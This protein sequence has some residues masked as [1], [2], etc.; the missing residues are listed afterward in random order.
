MKKFFYFFIFV[1][2]FPCFCDTITG[3]IQTKEKKAISSAN[4]SIFN[5][6]QTGK[7][8]LKTVISD[9][10]GKFKIDNLETGYY[11]I[12]VQK[13]G[14]CDSTLGK[15][16][17]N[18][19]KF[20]VVK[21]EII[22]SIPGAISGFVY[23]QEGKPISGAK[24]FI[25][26]DIYT[27]T[28]SK[29]FYKL[30]GLNPGTKYIYVQADGFVKEH[31]NTVVEEG[32]E[33]GGINFSLPYAGS[34]K[35]IIVDSETEKPIDNVDI[36][37]SGTSFGSTKTNKNGYFYIDGLKPG[38]YSLYAYRQGYEDIRIEKKF[39]LKPK[40]TVDA[41]KIQMKIRAKYFHL[42]SKEWLFTP[43][44]KVK[45]YFNAFRI[46]SATID[47]Y[48]IDLLNEINKTKLRDISINEILMSS[49]LS[50]KSPVLSKKFEITYPTPLTE[51]Y[52]RSFLLD[53][54]PE[55]AYVFALKPEGFAEIKGWFF[56][57]DIGFISKISNK[58]TNI[59]LFSLTKGDILPDIQ[60]F[61]FD[62]LWN[63][64]AT[65][66]TDSNG[67][68]NFESFNKFIA[69]KGNSFAFS[70]TCNSIYGGTYENKTVYAYT[71]RPVYRP[72]QVVNFKAIPRIDMGDKYSV[73]EF[74]SCEIKVKLPDETVV[75]ETQIIPGTTNSIYGSYTLPEEPPL[76]TYKIEFMTIGKNELSGYCNFKVL[77]YRKPEFSIDI[78]TDKN[79]YLPGEKIKVLIT[80][81]YYFG[82]PVKNTDVLWAIYSRQIWENDNDDYEYGEEYGGW[83]KGGLVCSGKGTTDENGIYLIEIPTQLSYEIKQIFTIE[84]RMTDESRREIIQSTKI[85]IVPGS[86]EIAITTS[87]YIY[88][89]EEEIPVYLSIK[90]YD[91]REFKGKKQ[92]KLIVS[93]EKYDKNKRRWSYN[94]IISKNV[95]LN[96]A[97]TTFNIK[98]GI[99]G[100]IRII[101]QGIDEY[102]NI[103]SATKYV[104]IT[105][106]DY[107]SQW[108]GKKELEIVSD[109]KKY[110][111]GE[112]AKI[113]INSSYSDLTILYTIEGYEIFENRVIK[114]NG[115]SVLLELPIKYE[116]I[117]NIYITIC[118]V[119]NKSFLY[120]SKSLV[121]S[122]DD[123]FLNVEIT[124]DKPKYQP[125]EKAKYLIKIKDNTGN[126]VSAEFSMGVVDEA[127]Y[128]ISNE[129]V[130]EIGDFFY[131]LKGNNVITEYSF[132]RWYYGGAGKDFAQQDI[133][134]NFKD[135]AFWLPLALTD[136]N[137]IAKIEVELPDN[138]TTWRA[139]IRSVTNDTKVG[140]G[141]NN[142]T[143]AKPL[144]ANLITPRFFVE[145]DRLL[146]SGVIHNYTG[147]QQKIYT[148]IHAE[149]LDILEETEK[150]IELPSG[151]SARVDWKVKVNSVKHAIITLYAKSSEFSDGM[152][153]KIP[154]FLYGTDERYVFAGQC[155]DVRVDTFYL[156]IGTIPSSI[157]I[158]SYIY[159]S[160]VSGM[161]TSLEALS[162]YP[163]GC[164]EQTLNGFLPAIQV[165]DTL[166]KIKS[167]D[168]Y[169]LAS[170]RI[171]FEQMLKELPKKVSDG[172]IKL[173][174]YQNEDGG[175]G[176]WQNDIS[177]PYITGYVM[178]GLTHAKKSGYIVN[179]D[180]YQRGKECLKNMLNTV[181]DYNQKEF[182]LYV[183][184]YT[185]ENSLPVVEEIYNNRDKLNSYTIAQLCLILKEIGDTR[186]NTLLDELCTKLVKPT[187]YLN[188]WA[189]ED[190]NYSWIHNNIEATA[191][192]LCA[193]LAINPK[194]EEIPFIIRYLVM[195]KQGGLWM[196]TKDTAICL[197]AFTNYLMITDELS[198]DYT[199]ILSVNKKNIAEEKIDR[200]SIKKFMTTIDINT[201]NLSIGKINAIEIAK[202][203]QGNLYY[204]NVIK[205]S[206]KDI[207]IPPFDGGFKI[208]RRYTEIKSRETIDK[209]GNRI[210]VYDDIN[211]EVKSG[212]K[213]RVEIK[214]SG[215]EKY[216]Y[217]MIEDP[218]PSGCEVVSELPEDNW[219]YCRREIR[220]EK[221]IFFTTSW[222]AKEKTIVYYLR[223]ETPGSYN[224]LPTKAQLMY[225]P[226]IWGHSQGNN[227]IIKEK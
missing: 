170:D 136:E 114:M 152:E 219:W 191:W 200:E 201:E 177:N 74:S 133:R 42:A 154:V 150:I 10:N 157:D 28:N 167:Y 54:F 81:K 146:I 106:R 197:F 135:T 211:R 51:L 27:L 34:I 61:L 127:I 58:K 87:K 43:E 192:G 178:F 107:Y 180:R 216:E 105:G 193:I 171:K 29:G 92:L 38:Y 218:I 101:V 176:W 108:Y 224:I 56:V 35:G 36:S 222:G 69:V 203:G 70:D 113:L 141:K 41:G 132:Y 186:A 20:G 23:D 121:V 46:K 214:I 60:I 215:G 49:D 128:S 138:L 98:P 45:V 184:T 57:S 119:R 55:G 199:F 76:G 112:T 93:Q 115:N 116:F 89:P 168:L 75:Y 8:P 137:G 85:V 109:K 104:W 188:Y 48:E 103:I 12:V 59:T 84:V 82:T 144:M 1:F 217:V 164:V 179:E 67:Q 63:L 183:L 160:L 17:V 94:N 204:S 62:N 190:G 221:I 166:I 198:P 206:L 90:Y 207:S 65:T 226:E 66:T 196:S 4:V 53:Q 73:A 77:E 6:P 99:T 40:E 117:P 140:T 205:F 11:K 142:I 126:P 209:E 30:D 9:S 88:S 25:S 151:K 91:G 19:A 120:S 174:N 202:K 32:K 212:E 134:K 102:N 149:G 210:Y 213:I 145:N 122:C 5:I 125:G 225:L 96:N 52:D 172:L 7:T 111:P 182:I 95:I 148:K 194:R 147:S 195:K 187:P 175:W 153:L 124:S 18:Q 159:P 44:E 22:M 50:G 13:K 165:A 130:P 139:T 47:V 156:P 185:G 26:K 33:A 86:F 39:D 181:N 100:Y 131:G 223:A 162:K 24:V 189:V 227:L 169:F 37:C 110:K 173:Y 71:D 2:S 118:A 83:W 21:Y 161:F 143:T 64:K 80:A 123:K 72:G 163:Y 15:I 155:D 31:K 97:K 3:I 78:K 158:R 14:F 68:C 79:V 220:D 16:E 208:L 129:L